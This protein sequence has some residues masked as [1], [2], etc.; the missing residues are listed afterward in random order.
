MKGERQMKSVTMNLNAGQENVMDFINDWDKVK[1]HVKTFIRCNEAVNGELFKPYL[2]DMSYVYY[3]PLDDFMTTL[4]VGDG[5]DTE[6]MTVKITADYLKR[7]DI[8]ATELH[9]TAMTNTM[10]E[11][12]PAMGNMITMMFGGEFEPV[13]RDTEILPDRMGIIST[14]DKVRGAMSV[15]DYDLMDRVAEAYGGSVIVLPSSIHEVLTTFESDDIQPYLEMV[16]QVNKTEVALKDK[17]SDHV[18]R[19]VKGHRKLEVA[20]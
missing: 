14:L 2:E 9:T 17:L 19:Y 18:Y 16:E 13:T 12:V 15:F 20:G 4:P 5:M 8:S 7:W 10:R 6:G 11:N 3:L 1:K